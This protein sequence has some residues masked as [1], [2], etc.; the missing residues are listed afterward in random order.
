MQEQMTLKDVAILL[1]FSLPQTRLYLK[2]A[3]I[4]KVGINNLREVIYNTESINKLHKMLEENY[5]KNRSTQCSSKE[6]IELGC[7]SHDRNTLKSVPTTIF[8]RYKDFA[9]VSHLYNKLEVD[10]YLESKNQDLDLLDFTQIKE[11]TGFKTNRQLERALTDC[12]IKNIKKGQSRTKYYRV[13]D[14]NKFN[15]LVRE[16]YLYNKQFMLTVKQVRELDINKSDLSFLKAYKA[17]PLD[18]V[19]EYEGILSLYEKKEVMEKL[20]NKDYLSNSICEKDAKKYLG[21]TNIK[22][23]KQIVEEYNIPYTSN[24]TYQIIYYHKETIENLKLIIDENYSNNIKTKITCD[25]IKALGFSNK[26]IRKLNSI[27]TK[28]IDNVY[29]FAK[30]VVFYDRKQFLELAENQN[31]SQN[32]YSSVQVRKLLNL[33]QNL[34]RYFSN[35]DISPIKV[36]PSTKNYWLKKDIDDVIQR[37]SNLYEHYNL[38][39][40]LIDEVERL[41]GYDINSLYKICSRLNIQVLT[42]KIPKEI[43]FNK[44]AKKHQ[45]FYKKEIDNIHFTINNHLNQQS[46]N[47]NINKVNNSAKNNT[48]RMPNSKDYSAISDL[49]LLLQILEHFDDEI[50]QKII[51]EVQN[52]SSSTLNDTGKAIISERDLI[53]VLDYSKKR[54]D[55]HMKGFNLFKFEFGKIN[56]YIRDDCFSLLKQLTKKQDDLLKSNYLINEALTKVSLHIL[57]KE[58]LKTKIPSDLTFG[59]LK[60]DKFVYSKQHID[61]YSN[62]IQ[63]SN[64]IEQYKNKIDRTTLPNEIFL[65]A[66]KNLNLKFIDSAKNTEAAWF[67]FV[68][69]KLLSSNGNT[70]SIK[71][72]FVRFIKITQLLKSALVSK[73]IIEMTTSEI[74]F[75]FLN[76]KILITYKE[77]L[78][79]FLRNLSLSTPNCNYIYSE[80]K[81]P[82]HEKR[83]RAT[84]INSNNHIYSTKEFLTLLDYVKDIDFHKHNAISELSISSKNNKIGNYES[85][86]LYVMLHLNNAWR[87]DDFIEKIP[88]VTLPSSIKDYKS[89]EKYNLDLEESRKVVWELTSKLNNIQHN[90]NGKKA[91]FFIS[92]DMI[93]PV[94]NALILCELKAQL[95]K[96]KGNKL[97]YLSNSNELTKSMHDKF[98]KAFPMS[99]F[100]FKSLKTNSTFITFINSILKQKTNRNP[101]E[102]TKFIRN[103]DSLNTTNKYVHIDDEHLNK[104]SLELFDK[105]NFGYTYDYLKQLVIGESQKN[106]INSD[107][108][109]L[110]S[111]VFG[112]IYKIEIFSVHLKAIEEKQ[113]PLY[114]FVN[115][116]SKENRKEIYDLINM[117]Q[118][119]AK[120]EFWQCI[121]GNC[122]YLDRKCDSCPFAIPHFYVLTKVVQNLNNLIPKLRHIEKITYKGEKVR[123]ANLLYKNLT[124][125]S[126]AKKQFGES[127]LSAFLG[128][129]YSDFLN[130]IRSLEGIYENLTIRGN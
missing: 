123:L 26:S 117:R 43:R 95:V 34:S 16:R 55:E 49:N 126:V 97:I 105:G 7:N 94:A 70:Q 65:E 29:E 41:I 72:L 44:F 82:Y 74:N 86:W 36:S 73:E 54:F 119:P 18:R 129:D 79:A 6:L 108:K 13:V 80:L 89:F 118:L 61:S 75:T 5:K 127:V 23:F 113:M 128:K 83:Q 38:N 8:D 104:I 98:F 52:Y 56:Y 114:E 124:L 88:R 45:V 93:I 77:L 1:N 112:D 50:K 58:E 20:K 17:E 101:L 110:F 121:L 21:F 39:Y 35:F 10:S 109:K 14:V 37:A 47:T 71:K 91:F 125:L 57:N 90:K 42:K 63:T 3:S 84:K 53:T 66:I 64:L 51:K 116:L 24:G 46:N 81:N 120:E 22:K 11:I 31:I 33:P 106:S 102:I 9:G 32:Y 103:H 19:H 62:S 100:Q 59:R 15:N 130:T 76:N 111:I 27:Y 85:I 40:Y 30:Y 60:K 107:E 87:S 25:E 122:L 68:S 4:Q 78:Y 28:P 96:T 12:R 48:N 2:A 69:T 115:N 92:E 99:N 67:K